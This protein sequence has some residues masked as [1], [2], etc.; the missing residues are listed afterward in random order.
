M[1]V[2]RVRSRSRS[3]LLWNLALDNLSGPQN[4]GCVACRAVVTIDPLTGATTYNVEYYALGQA[5]VAVDPGAQRVASNTFDGGIET[6]AF[7]N[8]DGSKASLVLN[9]SQHWLCQ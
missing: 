1:T 3:V 9:Q 2:S 7:L 6:V 4:G 8:P 5:S